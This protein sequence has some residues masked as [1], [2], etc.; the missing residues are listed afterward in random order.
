[1]VGMC[2]WDGARL[3][4]L[5]HLC[6][7]ISDFLPNPDQAHI[8]TKYFVHTCTEYI[9]SYGKYSSLLQQLSVRSTPYRYELHPTAVYY[10]GIDCRLIAMKYFTTLL[11]SLPCETSTQKTCAAAAVLQ[12]DT[13][14]LLHSCTAAATCFLRNNICWK[15]EIGN[16]YE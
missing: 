2:N 15:L 9:V 1:M 12:Y 16:G 13:A 3:C 4:P 5:K 11:S 8:S 10:D 6:K 7:R 14:A